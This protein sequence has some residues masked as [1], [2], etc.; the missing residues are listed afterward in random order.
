MEEVAWYASEWLTDI[1][2]GR[3]VLKTNA[4]MTHT[5]NFTDA[6]NFNAAMSVLMREKVFIA[7]DTLVTAYQTTGQNPYPDPGANP[8]AV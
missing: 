2:Q 5:L 8:P 3:V 7:G 4:G 1:K 6:S